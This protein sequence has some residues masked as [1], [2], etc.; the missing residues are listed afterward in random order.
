ML[1]I[2]T[3]TITIILIVTQINP[4]TIVRDNFN[5]DETQAQV[6]GVMEV[7]ES[8]QENVALPKSDDRELT[9]RLKPDVVQVPEVSA[10]SVIIIDKESKI[11]LY[12]KDPDVKSSIASITKLITALVV[13]DEDPDFKQE[14]IVTDD[15]RREGGRI[16]LFDG[17]R[18]TI[19][20]LL[21]TSLVGSA[22]TATIALV[23][24][25]GL[26]EQEFVKKMNTKAE[27]LGLENTYF[28]D[29][30]GLSSNNISTAREVA[31]LLEQTLA[32]EIIQKIISQPKYILKTKQG[33]QR[34]VESTNQLL[35]QKNGYEVIGGKTG[36][37]GVAGFCFT[38]Q[39]K[40]DEHEIISVVLDSSGVDLRFTE[41]DELVSW[42]FE[43]YLW[44]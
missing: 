35:K 43:N 22:N 26:S 29:P 4:I 19:E 31:S 24:A 17:D 44:P 28:I 3:V 40:Q 21:N 33:K 5:V 39:F 42:V 1:I 15:D 23:H 2:T 8:A 11:I 38:G 14:Y 13:L 7:A 25:L 10:Q 41:T 18:V 20:T 37:L 6:M 12:E 32:N 9:L 30:I 34:L 36:Y 27:E 16:F